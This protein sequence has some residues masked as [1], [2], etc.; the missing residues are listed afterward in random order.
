MTDK[1]IIF[2]DIDGTLSGFDGINP[3]NLEIIK[4]VR[5]QGH[6]VFLNTGRSLSWAMLPKTVDLKDYDGIVS[7]MGT[8]ILMNGEVLYENLIEKEILEQII[9][10]F[11][12]LDYCFF[13]SGV[14]ESFVANPTLFFMKYPLIE[15]KNE[16]NFFEKYPNAKIQK[17]ELFAKT[18]KDDVDNIA[19]YINTVRSMS[20]KLITDEDMDF[21]SKYF[22]VYDYGIYIECAPKGVT[23][24]KG[25]EFVMNKLGIPKDRTIAIGDSINDIDML[26]CAGISV[27][28]ANAN[29]KVKAI[30]SMVTTSCEDGGVGDA[31]K[32]LILE[33]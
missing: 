30:C 10:R 11:I 25:M 1:Y 23:K 22:D 24:A 17:I 19:Q 26:K 14:T 16:E 32:K 7:G 18:D 31:L 20:K 29:D 28:M 21:L 12:K 5:E 13:V 8:Y 3:K 33:K 6:Y 15:L 27:A 2:L 9:D 4:K